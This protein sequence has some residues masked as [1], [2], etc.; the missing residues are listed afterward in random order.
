MKFKFF[1]K[2]LLPFV[3]IGSVLSLIFLSACSENL[4][5]V[6]NPITINQNFKLTPAT[7]KNKIAIFPSEGDYKNNPINRSI[8]DGLLAL[9]YQ[10]KTYNAFFVEKN[11][12][13]SEKSYFDA[14]DRAISF[15]YNY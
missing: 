6:E 10:L 9:T 13:Q 5:Q 4:P 12:S 3:S 15:G 11:D 8:T 1:K 14:Y 7:D 2:R